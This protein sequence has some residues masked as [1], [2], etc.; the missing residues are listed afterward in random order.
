M[1]RSLGDLQPRGAETRRSWYDWLERP[2]TVSALT[3]LAAIHVLGEARAIELLFGKAPGA[4]TAEQDQGHEET[5]ERLAELES[6]LAAFTDI[7]HTPQART[8]VDAGE[9]VEDQLSGVETRLAQVAE[10]VGRLQVTVETQGE[11][12]DRIAKQVLPPRSRS[13]TGDTETTVPPSHRGAAT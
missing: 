13:S 10:V 3:A 2:E 7:V 5:I 6:Q 8:T 9:L 11:L 4:A 12:L 1:V